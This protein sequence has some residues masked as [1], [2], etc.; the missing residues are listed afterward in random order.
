MPRLVTV[1]SSLALGVLLAGC[2]GGD[3]TVVAASCPEIGV[4][5]G[6]VGDLDYEGQGGGEGVGDGADGSGGI[7]AGGA[8]GQFRNALVIVTFPD[9]SELGRA[10]T[11][12]VKGMVTIRPGRDYAGA[13]LIEVTGAPDASYFEE[14]KNEYVPFGADRRIRAIVP[15]ITGNIGITPF[16]E[17]AYQ[18]AVSCQGG[19]GP[20]SVCGQ[21][22]GQSNETLPGVGAVEASNEAVRVL[23]NRQFPASLHLSSITRLPFIVSDQTGSGEVSTTARGKYGLVNIAFSK[24]AAM[25]NTRADAPTLLAI[26]QLSQDLLD[27]KLDARTDGLQAVPAGS[28]TY[29]PH[30]LTSELSSALS[31]QSFRFGN[32]DALA[33]LPELVSFGNVRYDSYF[34]DAR[35][36]SS[37]SANTV[38]IATETNSSKRTAG[39]IEEYVTPADDQRGFMVYGNLGSGGLFIKTDSANSSS[40]ILVVGDNVNGE[41]GTGNRASI[42]QAATIDLP[43]VL[44]HVAG[45][46]GHTLVRLADGRVYA[47]GDNEFGQ[48]GQGGEAGRPRRSLTALPVA[49][50]A[51]AIAIGASNAASFALLE[52]GRVYSWG[53]SWGFGA[54]GD[55]QADS[56]RATPMPVLEQGGEVLDG[57]VQLSARDNDVI[58]LKAD[59]TVLTW[60]S[61]SQRASTVLP[62]LVQPGQTVATPIAG[63]PAGQP[64]RKVLTEQGL[65]VV[66]LGGQE[67]AGAV[68]AWGIHF[69]LSADGF[70]FDLQPRRVLNLPPV[71]DIM[72]GGFHGYGSRPFDRLTGMAVDYQSRYWKLRGRV[73][74][75]YDPANPTAQRRPQGFGARPNCDE[76]HTVRPAI[77]PQPPLTGT[78]CGPL[79]SFKLSNGEPAL[80]NANSDCTSCHNGGS[81][82]NGTVL[83]PLE[84]V[85]PALPPPRPVVEA[86]PLTGRCELPLAHPP[87]PDGT[88]C[89]SCHNSIIAAPLTCSTETAPLPPP[90]ATTATV[91]V[92][93]DNVQ[94]VVG[95][96]IDGGV[97]NDSSPLLG[98]TTS[99]RL[100]AGEA[101]RILNNGAD[102]GVATLESSGAWRFQVGNLPDGNYSFSAQIQNAGGARGVVVTPPFRLSIATGNVTNAAQVLSADDNFRSNFSSQ[103]GPVFS[104][105]ATDDSTPTI[106]GSLGN[107][108]ASG[109]K[110]VLRRLGPDGQIAE[111]I[112]R[113]ENTTQWT[114][115]DAGLSSQSRAE[116]AQYQY[117]AVVVGANGTESR[118]QDPPFSLIF[119][120]V[121]PPTPR[122]ASVFADAPGSANIAASQLGGDIPDG[123]GSMDPSLDVSVMVSGA[124]AEDRVELLVGSSV[125]GEVKTGAADSN[126]VRSGTYRHDHGISLAG[127]TVA[128]GQSPSSLVYRAR[129]VDAA[130]NQ[131]AL[132][133]SRTVRVGFFDCQVLWQRAGANPDATQRDKYRNKTRRHTDTGYTYD[134]CT[135]CHENTRQRLKLPDP[136]TYWCSFNSRRLDQVL[137]PR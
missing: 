47:F 92:A 96:L 118:P 50:P 64:V 136:G 31:Q 123:K 98:G 126:G 97:T 115:T 7:G 86:E 78:A 4:C 62:Q 8:L 21:S 41:L 75:R 68:Y 44:T 70:L 67:Q 32:S 117:T 13:L 121:R 60:G 61:F 133:A 69:D 30:T 15:R 26:E 55:G 100:L 9:G 28:R 127:D 99:A 131:S 49:L 112:L 10:K 57:V 24:Q 104:G 128:A 58:V 103:T 119:D 52:D 56:V 71:R 76:C 74:E 113:P 134:Q 45:G 39:Q 51:G 108:L 79:P 85:V 34:F 43:G 132:S 59:G 84:C 35:L 114:Y 77:V 120:N 80:V 19:S 94:P 135:R 65:F 11:D 48:L 87:A 88:F 89:S 63:L 5:T 106:R 125:L 29:D 95:N 46:Y 116:G 38:A 110:I 36:G 1:I 6:F 81:L 18:L 22:L 101:V 82:A 16:T 73:A 129:L 2:G 17:A 54:L 130:G 27:G 53:A 25:Y 23:T 93:I 66:L 107:P 90:S 91:T 111:T 20:V 122:L 102:I 12:P 37:G 124:P 72:P 137:L 42:D 33:S 109:E 14:G 3:S 40:K 105:G 83:P